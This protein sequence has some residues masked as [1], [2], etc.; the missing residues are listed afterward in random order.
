METWV[1]MRG[2]PRHESV[3]CEECGTTPVQVPGVGWRRKGTNPATWRHLCPLCADDRERLTHA[4]GR[5]LVGMVEALP[6]ER[7]ERAVSDCDWCS[8]TNCGWIEHRLAAIVR[9]VVVNHMQ[10]RRDKEGGSH[11]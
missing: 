6:R 1:V 5:V 7:L 11:G 4:L 8:K 3:V 2:T 10:L 9:D